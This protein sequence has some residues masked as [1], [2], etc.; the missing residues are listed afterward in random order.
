MTMRSILATMLLFGI[1]ACGSANV[2]ISESGS[3]SVLAAP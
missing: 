3:A 2:V 1:A